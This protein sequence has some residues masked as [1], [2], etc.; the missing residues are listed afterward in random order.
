MV[1]V[2]ATQCCVKVLAQSVTP[3]G[4][5]LKRTTQNIHKQG[6]YWTKVKAETDMRYKDKLAMRH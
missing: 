6:F 3:I 2:I 4:G 5:G 1:C